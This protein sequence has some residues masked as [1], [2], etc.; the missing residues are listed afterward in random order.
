MKSYVKKGDIVNINGVW[1]NDIVEYVEKNNGLRV[2]TSR[3][4]YVDISQ[5]TKIEDNSIY[6][7]EQYL[8]DKK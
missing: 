3:G 2:A 5:I 6:S 4:Y 1:G 8:E 7:K